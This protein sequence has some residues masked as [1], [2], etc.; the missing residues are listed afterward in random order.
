MSHTTSGLFRGADAD[1]ND[2]MDREEFRRFLNSQHINLSDADFEATFRQY[3]R[4]NSGTISL[5]EFQAHVQ[6]RAPVHHTSHVTHHAPMRTSSSHV[7]HHAPVHHT[8]HVT[9]APMRTSSH[10]GQS[11]TRKGTTVTVESLYNQYCGHK[12]YMDSND[13]IRFFGD[14]G[15][16]INHTEC[17]IHM[18]HIGCHHGQLTIDQFR[19][20]VRPSHG[21]HTSHTTHHAPVRTSHHGSSYRY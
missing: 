7:T 3:D 16:R 9:H 8:S 12:G 5:A 18:R 15:K 1:G 14:S 6:T 17:E 20:F 4:D 13:T 10:H 11:T 2:Q 21:H 19:S